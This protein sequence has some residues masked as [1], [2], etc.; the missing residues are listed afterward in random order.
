MF[1]VKNFVKIIVVGFVL[2][3]VFFVGIVM[4]EVIISFVKFWL[5][6]NSRVR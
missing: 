1:C 2:G 3:V 4:F 6:E 5:V